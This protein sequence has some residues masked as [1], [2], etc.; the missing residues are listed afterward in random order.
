MT[1]PAKFY[2]DRENKLV[3][4]VPFNPFGMG[5]LDMSFDS[6]EDEDPMETLRI[7][8]PTYCGAVNHEWEH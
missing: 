8:E 5:T 4:P 2:L 3:L 1:A 7:A 6:I